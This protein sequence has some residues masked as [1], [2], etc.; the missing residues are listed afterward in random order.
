MPMCHHDIRFVL[1]SLRR[2]ADLDVFALVVRAWLVW[3]TPWAWV[4]PGTQRNASSSP[5]RGGGGAA[6]MAHMGHHH[7]GVVGSPTQH[8]AALSPSRGGGGGGGGFQPQWEGYVLASYDLYIE[9]GSTVVRPNSTNGLRGESARIR[10]E[11]DWHHS[12][13]VGVRAACESEARG[14]T[15]ESELP[16]EPRV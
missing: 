8:H 2:C 5:S 4:A 14:S 12:E 3:L 1:L 9:V 15:R 16:E 11:E 10:R 13:S 6:G 7:H